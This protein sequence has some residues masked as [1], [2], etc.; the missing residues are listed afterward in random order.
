M[1][2]MK[3]VMAGVAASGLL[4]SS[5]AYASETRAEAAAPQ[6]G[7]QARTLA[8]VSKVKRK[9][10]PTS[11]YVNSDSGSGLGVALGV[12]G[13]FAAGLAVCYIISGCGNHGSSSNASTG[14]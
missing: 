1:S 4:L 5:A 14:G 6:A 2:I 12:G 13:G 7:L 10:L 11:A 8:T 9:S 3:N